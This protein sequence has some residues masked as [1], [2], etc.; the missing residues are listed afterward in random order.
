MMALAVPSLALLVKWELQRH[1]M[2]ERVYW[3]HAPSPLRKPNAPNPNSLQDRAALVT[4][5]GSAL[6]VLVGA[7]ALK[8]AGAGLSS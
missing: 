6:V 8:L 3:K 2:S 4:F 1:V 5:G 7:A